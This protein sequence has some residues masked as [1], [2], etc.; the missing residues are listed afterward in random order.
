LDIAVVPARVTQSLRVVN[1]VHTQL[2]LGLVWLPAGRANEN[3]DV[4]G[5]D[6]KLP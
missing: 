4:L 1:R 2:Q 6:D 5:F 3:I